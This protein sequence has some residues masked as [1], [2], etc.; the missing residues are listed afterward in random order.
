MQI[1][2]QAKNMRNLI[3]RYND[4]EATQVL[5]IEF[6]NPKMEIEHYMSLINEI[7]SIDT[8]MK[9]IKKILHEPVKEEELT[10][11]SKING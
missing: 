9:A 2:N 3:D 5:Y 6:L 11:E 8:E 10:F 7:V 1:K 4:L